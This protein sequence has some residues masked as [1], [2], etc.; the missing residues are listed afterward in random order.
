MS[1]PTFPD[2]FQSSATYSSGFYNWATPRAKSCGQPAKICL[3]RDTKTQTCSQHHPANHSIVRTPSH[4]CLQRQPQTWPLTR[5]QYPPASPLI[6]IL[7]GG[8]SWPNKSKA[9]R[10]RGFSPLDKTKRTYG[11]FDPDVRVSRETNDLD[12]L[13]ELNVWLTGSSPGCFQFRS[14]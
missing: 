3:Q 4:D 13:A 1:H 12:A 5:P 9:A 2:A 14:E 7:R 11:W 10:R 6:T 8:R